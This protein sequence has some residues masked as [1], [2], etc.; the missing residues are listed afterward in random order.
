M[1]VVIKLVVIASILAGVNLHADKRSIDEALSELPTYIGYLNDG[2]RD[3]EEM[4]EECQYLVEAIPQANN[5]TFIERANHKTKC[6]QIV[7]KSFRR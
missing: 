1:K 2:T 3:Y 7:R 6:K 4:I 5:L